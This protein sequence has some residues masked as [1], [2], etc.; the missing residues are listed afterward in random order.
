MDP[1]N[2]L[3]DFYNKHY[4]KLKAVEENKVT[5]SDPALRN[6]YLGVYYKLWEGRIRDAQ[7]LYGY[8]AENRPKIN[9]SLSHMK[10]K[11]TL[12][13]LNNQT[14]SFFETVGDEDSELSYESDAV[15]PENMS[16]NQKII[17]QRAKSNKNPLARDGRS[18]LLDRYEPITVYINDDDLKYIPSTAKSKKKAISMILDNLNNWEY[19]MPTPYSVN[20]YDKDQGKKHVNLP[21]TWMFDIMYFSNYGNQ[22]IKDKTDERAYQ[23]AIYLIGININTRFAVGRRINGKTVDDLIP[24]FQDLL[25]HELRN[26]I[27]LLI[28]DGEKAISSKK[29]EEFCRDKNINVKITYPGIHTQTAPIDRLCRTLRDY[30]TK[31]YLSK[32][33]QGSEFNIPETIKSYESNPLLYSKALKNRMNTEA[34]YTRRIFDG[35]HKLLLAPIPLRYVCFGDPKPHYYEEAKRNFN[36]DITKISTINLTSLLR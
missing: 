25:R 26:N 36:M 31:M 20:L 22:I 23:Q 18:I 33:N 8:L 21:G 6:F 24:P 19:F 17:F 10:V 16:Q 35:E 11:R 27:N 14:R 7:T 15:Y 1:R 13:N 3:E 28:F 34:I 29:F 4:D 30:F 32:V 2:I 9:L 12:E 5:V